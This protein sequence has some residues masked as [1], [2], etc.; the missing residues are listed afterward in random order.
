MFLFS[1]GHQLQLL[2]NTYH[3]KSSKIKLQTTVFRKLYKELRLRIAGV[4]G[5]LVVHWLFRKR[6]SNCSPT[7]LLSRRSGWLSV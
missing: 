6:K 3:E 4:D 1:F 2:D 7:K 5:H